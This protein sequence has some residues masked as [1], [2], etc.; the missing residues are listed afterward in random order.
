MM[1][2]SFA[3]DVQDAERARSAVGGDDAACVCAVDL[4]E[5]IEALQPLFG[6][7]GLFVGPQ[8]GGDE[9]VVSGA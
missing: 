9:N 8:G 4:F 5:I 2:R 6:P 7:C 1:E 3:S